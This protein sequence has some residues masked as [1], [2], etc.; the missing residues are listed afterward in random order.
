M[1]KNLL[2][3]VAILL[4]A[5]NVF[6][7]GTGPSS[8]DPVDSAVAQ[9]GS[10]GVDLNVTTDDIPIAGANNGAAVAQDGSTATDTTLSNN[11]LEVNNDAST[12]D[13]WNKTVDVDLEKNFNLDLNKQDNDNTD[14]F[15]TK[16][17]DIDANFDGSVNDSYN[18]KADV[19][20]DASKN[21]NDSFKKDIDVTVDKSVNDSYN[22]DIDMTYTDN[23][24]YI[25][26]KMV[27]ISAQIGSSTL[28]GANGA[29]PD[30]A[31]GTEL[32]NRLEITDSM[33]NFSG[34]LNN[35]V[36]A[37]NFNNSANMNN[38][39]VGGGASLQ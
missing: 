26:A 1:L 30:C 25:D 23:S 22:K 10:L 34:I 24:A 18:K 17:V 35:A 36:S 3:I 12:N 8:D 21:I 2:A 11:T 16:T 37:G 31:G 20:I 5:G 19:D 33:N 7:T 9:N 13:S 39:A 27:Q 15:N 38:I 28:I 14:S 6:A 32:T 29:G 4:L